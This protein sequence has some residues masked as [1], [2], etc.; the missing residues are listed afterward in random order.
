M[1]RLKKLGV[2]S[3]VYFMKDYIHGFNSFDISIGGVTEYK[4][5]TKLNIKLFKELF[6]IKDP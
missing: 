5:G 3:K 2:D 4:N 6:G 1:T